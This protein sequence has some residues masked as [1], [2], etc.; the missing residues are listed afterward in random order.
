MDFLTFILFIIFVIL[1]IIGNV[2]KRRQG[3]PDANKTSAKR[4]NPTAS[5][6]ASTASSAEES[7]EKR[8]EQARRRVEQAKQ[9]D[10]QGDTRPRA[11][12]RPSLGEA[13]QASARA[14][15]SPGSQARASRGQPSQTPQ[16]AQPRA[17]PDWGLQQRGD[18]AYGLHQQGL[19][20]QTLE[21]TQALGSSGRLSGLDDR[22]SPLHNYYTEDSQQRPGGVATHGSAVLQGLIWHE[23]LS[24]PLA[25]RKPDQRR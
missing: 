1:P 16:R 25:K 4:N 9:Q 18:N 3:K 17:N 12:Q 6:S 5:A 13:T 7:F 20:G 22:R 23:I 15:S 14:T 21:T 8:L 19:T 24:K 2:N 11:S 10:G